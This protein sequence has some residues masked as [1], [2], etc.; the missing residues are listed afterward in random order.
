MNK[1][2]KFLEI[3][4]EHQKH[5][6][7]VQG[8][9]LSDEIVFSANDG[10]EFLDFTP[11]DLNKIISNMVDCGIDSECKNYASKQMNLIKMLTLA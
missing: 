6:R 7:L 3:M 4:K 10:L 5:D 8:D 11:K 2:T 1:L 9:W